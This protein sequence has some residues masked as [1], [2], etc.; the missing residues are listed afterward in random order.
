MKNKYGLLFAV[1]TVISYLCFVNT[2]SILHLFAWIIC[3]AATIGY[4]IKSIIEE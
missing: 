3:F 2:G 1:L 4:S